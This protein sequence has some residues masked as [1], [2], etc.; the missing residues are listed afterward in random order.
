MLFVFISAGMIVPSYYAQSPI[1]SGQHYQ[2]SI[3]IATTFPS[4]T[5]ASRSPGEQSRSR[6]SGGVSKVQGRTQTLASDDV[7]IANEDSIEMS[8]EN[9]KVS[10]DDES[11]ANRKEKTPM[12]LVNELAR[13]NKVQ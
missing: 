10:E 6:S 9:V 2:P 4:Y 5:G 1:Q 7:T 8:G 11:M 13:F 3:S 12:C